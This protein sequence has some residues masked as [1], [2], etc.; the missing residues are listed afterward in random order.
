[1]ALVYKNLADIVTLSRAS[2]RTRTNSAGVLTTLASGIFGIDYDPS[3]LTVRGMPV[4]EQRTNILSR[5]TDT[6]LWTQAEISEDGSVTA[7]DGTTVPIW[8]ANGVAASHRLTRTGTGGAAGNTDH[9]PSIFVHVPSGSDV[10]RLFLRAR[11]GSDGSSVIILVAGSGAGATFTYV[12]TGPFGTNPPASFGAGDFHA[13]YWGGGWHRIWYKSALSSITTAASQLDIAFSPSGTENTAGTVNTRAAFWQG[14]LEQGS[15]ASSPILTTTAAATRLADSL[16]IG[17]LSPWHNAV[18]GTWYVKFIPMTISASTFPRQI[19]ANDGT[20]NNNIRI[21]IS[22]STAFSGA[23]TTGGVAQAAITAGTPTAL[24]VAK[25]ALSYKENDFQA[26]AN[27]TLGTADVSGTV[28]TVT[29]VYLGRDPSGVYSNSWLQ[30][31]IY[32]PAVKNTQT[33]TA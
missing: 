14:Q 32:Y 30:Q 19:S 9:A 1:M 3:T 7:P 15:F 22:G 8:L 10:T 17:T 16:T 12:S 24:T 2:A 25:V 18:E 11:A 20:V 21:G 31:V 27:G 28:P 13:E 33:L 6:T 4:E 5:S 26:A 29:G 23:V